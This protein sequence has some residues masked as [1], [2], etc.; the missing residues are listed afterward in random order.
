MSYVE[1]AA[2]DVLSRARAGAGCCQAVPAAAVRDR[3]VRRRA[4][5]RARRAARAVDRA[6]FAARRRTSPRSSPTRPASTCSAPTSSAATCSHGSS[7]ARARRSWRACSRRCS[8]WRSRVPIGLVAGYYRG[9]VDPVISRLT[10]VLLAFPFLILAV[11]LAA[12]LGPSLLNATIALGHRRRARAHPRR[13]RRDARAA[14]GGLRARGGRE[15]RGRRRDPLPPHRPEHDLDA[16][17]PGDGDD[18]G[19]DHRRGGALVPR[20]RRP[21]A[22]AVLG[23]DADRR[24]ELPL[25]GA[26]ARGLSRGS[27]SSSARSSFNLLGDGLRDILDPRTTR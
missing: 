8:R 26:A 18:P 17:R 20:P 25:A 15:R 7:G 16:A 2:A 13:A 10:D 24:A 6:V 22:D 23:R 21:A 19:R 1:L 3:R 9:W 14:R 27:R 4:G 11:G 12:I 5:V